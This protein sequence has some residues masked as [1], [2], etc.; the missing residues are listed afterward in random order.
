MYEF[1]ILS[2]NL[3]DVERKMNDLSKQDYTVIQGSFIATPS[4]NGAGVAISVCM[5]KT[6]TK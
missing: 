3:I 2:G 4:N 6:V 5:Y 1:R